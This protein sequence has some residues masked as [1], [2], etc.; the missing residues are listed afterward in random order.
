VVDDDPS[1]LEVATATLEHL[2][3]EA[4]GVDSGLE[5]FLLLK[6]EPDR[7]SLL[8]SDYGMNELDGLDLGRLVC[9]WRYVRG[10]ARLPMLLM[11]GLDGI[12]EQVLNDAGFSR[13]LKKPFN[14]EEL[15]E[16]V[17][18]ALADGVITSIEVK[19]IMDIRTSSPAAEIDLPR[20]PGRRAFTNLREEASVERVVKSKLRTL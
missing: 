7:F 12:Y 3:F 15:G 17:E 4:V 6:E 10:E 14:M 16:A 8:L 5:A 19:T 13:M 1:V 11:S 20:A 9:L 18:A 2:G